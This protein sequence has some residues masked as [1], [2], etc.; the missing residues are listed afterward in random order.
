MKRFA[1]LVFAS[2]LLA[3]AGNAANTPRVH[4]GIVVGSGHNDGPAP[5]PVPPTDGSN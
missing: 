3:I 1:S 4:A 5:M 2:L